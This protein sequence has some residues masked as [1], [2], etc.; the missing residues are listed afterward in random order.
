[1]TFEELKQHA[2]GLLNLY[3][4]PGCTNHHNNTKVNK[5]L[6]DTAYNRIFERDPTFSE[7]LAF[8]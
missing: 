7:R 8:V 6:D 4:Q 5:R 1:M 2:R 3:E